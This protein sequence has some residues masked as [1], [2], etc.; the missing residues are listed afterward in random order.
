M[1]TPV[2]IDN[3]Q[4]MEVWVSGPSGANRLFIYTGVAV[5]DVDGYLLRMG[6]QVTVLAR[7]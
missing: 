4:E 5:S 3:A 2:S 7:I 6:Y 1:I